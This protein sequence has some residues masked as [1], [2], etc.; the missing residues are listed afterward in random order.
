MKTALIG[1]T[2]FVGSN[3]AKQYKFTDF[4]NSKN[5]NTIREKKYDLIVSA[6]STALR[7][8]ANNE[9]KKDWAGIKKLL[10]CLKEVKAK[11]FVLIS[12]IDVYPKKNGIDED[13]K[14]TLTNLREPYGNHRYK[15]EKFII[16]I[17][18]NHTVLR[19]PQIYGP[20]ITKGFIYDLIH[21]NALD[22]THKDSKLQFY[23]APNFKKDITIARKKNISIL[24]MAVAPTSAKEVAKYSRDLNFTTV[25]ENPPFTFNMQTKYAKAFG[26]RGRYLYGKRE[27]LQQL[28]KFITAE[29]K[30][31]KK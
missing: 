7:W 6:G 20:G 22:F 2:G 21:N 4:Y 11:H 29:R 15:M 31:N 12:T 26:K 8:K 9:S 5:I 1:Y 3:L 27:T 17:F 13:Y 30:K 25:T 23:Y 10:D 28:K 14:I 16:D 18:P 19:C 24:N